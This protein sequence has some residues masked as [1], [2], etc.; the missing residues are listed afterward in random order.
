MTI[1]HGP[2][3]R[4]AAARYQRVMRLPVISLAVLAVA[5]IVARLLDVPW[6]FGF[7]FAVCTHLWF[8]WNML[9]PRGSLFCPTIWRARRCRDRRIALTFD[10][11]P[12]DTITP[13]V[14]RILQEKNVR[15]TFFLIGRHARK[16]PD[17]VRNIA[18]AGHEIANHSF[19]HPRHIY[20]WSARSILRDAR[21]TQRILHRIT[22]RAPRLYRPPIGFRSPEMRTAMNVLG[23]SLVT[24]TARSADTGHTKPAAII[25]NLLRTAQPGAILLCHDGSDINPRPNRRALL[26]ALPTIIDLL[27]ARGYRFVTISDLLDTSDRAT[28]SYAEGPS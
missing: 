27:H 14:L 12:C 6:R 7:A 17:L 22:G 9:L 18:Q 13:E 10:D 23:L 26:T 15:A 25:R 19:R 11:G 2:L 24:F 16:L 28:V 5:L 1:P 3:A 4:R 8:L 21:L 20:A